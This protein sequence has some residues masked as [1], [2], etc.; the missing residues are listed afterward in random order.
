MHILHW[1]RAKRNFIKHTLRWNFQIVTRTICIFT[2]NCRHRVYGF[3]K[4]CSTQL[5]CEDLH[6]VEE[7]AFSY[8]SNDAISADLRLTN[9]DFDEVNHAK[10]LQGSNDLFDTCR[11]G[12]YTHILIHTHTHIYG[13]WNRNRT[14]PLCR[15]QN[16]TF[17]RRITASTQTREITTTPNIHVHTG[18]TDESPENLQGPAGHVPAS[19]LQ[20]F[21]THFF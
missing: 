21:W 16:S 20:Y 13:D 5:R 1:T 2:K 6:S 9:V 7:Y 18:L 14:R 8:N 12:G 11:S 15:C 19:N 3:Q 4:N 17:V 10:I